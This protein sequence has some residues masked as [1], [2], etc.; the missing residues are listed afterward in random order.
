MARFAV[1]FPVYF[2]S[3]Y[4]LKERNLLLNDLLASKS[5]LSV[6]DS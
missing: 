2:K 4:G 3:I 6:V 1:F 5:K